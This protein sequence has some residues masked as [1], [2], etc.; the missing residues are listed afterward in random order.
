MK[1]LY[2]TNKNDY[3]YLIGGGCQLD[4]YNCRNNDYPYYNNDSLKCHK[5]SDT[6]S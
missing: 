4:A 2:K 3:L 6:N 1:T 5:S